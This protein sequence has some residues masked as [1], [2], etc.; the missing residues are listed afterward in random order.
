MSIKYISL[1]GDP[2]EYALHREATSRDAGL[3]M[4]KPYVVVKT[5]E[6]CPD[7]QYSVVNGVV[8]RHH[9]LREAFH[10]TFAMHWILCQHYQDMVAPFYQLVEMILYD[11]DRPSQNLLA[12]LVP[13]FEHIQS[14]GAV[15]W[16]L[17]R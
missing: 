13:I 1:Q 4:P 6:G 9:S 8:T 7:I 12:P 3:G 16:P 17:I 11:F 14:S 10:F 2:K 5:V 15:F